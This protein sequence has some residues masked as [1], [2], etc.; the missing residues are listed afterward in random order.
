MIKQKIK[1][2]VK[3]KFPGIV[4]LYHNIRKNIYRMVNRIKNFYDPPVIV[5]LYHRIAD[6]EN[7]PQLLAVSIKNFEDQIKFLKENYSILSFGDKWEKGGKP[8]IIITFDDGYQDNYINAL[9]ILERYQVPATIFVSSGNI[10]TKKE[11]WWD[12][13]ERLFLLND[14]LPEKYHLVTSTGIYD[15]L[16]STEENIKDCYMKLHTILKEL[17][18]E[19]RT[20]ILEKME[21]ELNPTTEYRN[22]YRTMNTKEILEMDKSPYIVIGGHTVT[23]TKLAIQSTSMQKMEIEESK[24][25][26]E[27]LLKRPL[28]VFSY[29][30]GAKSDYTNDT[31]KLLKEVGYKKVA[32]NYPGTVHS[33][34]RSTYEIPRWLIR[35]WDRDVFEKKI[36]DFFI[37]G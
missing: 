17:Q 11:F 6:L 9:P 26:L 14:N 12:D 7:D 25:V 1:K 22:L 24:R 4:C 2:Q 13:I 10:D 18:P 29:P 28:T 3:K 5:L 23:H 35:N 37:N 32:A 27:N 16:L 36:K 20:Y 15:F 30:F 34:N 19:E 33:W 21:I 8:S 31:I